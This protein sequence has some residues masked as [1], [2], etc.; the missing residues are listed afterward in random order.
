MERL[1]ARKAIL[2]LIVSRVEIGLV[3]K[4]MLI[5]FHKT[6]TEPYPFDANP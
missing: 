1:A 3:L 4:P 6:R 5:S 2:G